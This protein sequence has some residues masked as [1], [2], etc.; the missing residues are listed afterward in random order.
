MSHWLTDRYLQTIASLRSANLWNLDVGLL[1]LPYLQHCMPPPHLS[2]IRKSMSDLISMGIDT[3]WFPIKEMRR[4]RTKIPVIECHEKSELEGT[5]Y[6]IHYGIH[7]INSQITWPDDVKRRTV[8]QFIEFVFWNTG[9]A[10]YITS[11][12]YYQSVYSLRDVYIHNTAEKYQ[13]D[14]SGQHRKGIE[15]KIILF[16][17]IKSESRWIG[18]H[19]RDERLKSSDDPFWSNPPE[20]PFKFTLNTLQ[21]SLSSTSLP[22]I[23]PPMESGNTGELMV[24]LPSEHDH[25][26]PKLLAKW[27]RQNV[28]SEADP[29]ALSLGIVL[30][31]WE[32]L[33]AKSR[34]K[35]FLISA[36][37]FTTG[38][39]KQ[40]WSTL[41]TDASTLK[42]GGLVA[43]EN[44]AFLV[45]K[46]Q[47]VATD[48]TGVSE[49]KAAISHCIQLSIPSCWHQYIST[50]EATA[51][52]GI[53]EESS[54]RGFSRKHGGV[55]PTIN[56]MARS[57]HAMLRRECLG[58]L[59]SHTLSGNIPIELQNRSAYQAVSNQKINDGFQAVIKTLVQKTMLYSNEYP[60]VSQAIYQLQSA[61]FH[62]S[63][64]HLIG[65]QL[66]AMQDSMVFTAP[67]LAANHSHMPLTCIV[68]DLNLLE[69]YY[70]WMQQFASADRAVG[71]L[72]ETTY[73]GSVRWHRDKDS[74][75]YE[76][77]K[78]QLPPERLL[79]QFVEVQ[80]A[81]KHLKRVMATYGK[82]IE[83]PIYDH[84]AMQFKV[85]A[86]NS[87]KASPLESK[88]AE[89]KAK[90]LWGYKP[91][92]ERSNAHRHW[93]ATKLT[94]Q[95]GESY[96]DLL[97]GHH[98]DGLDQLAPESSAS[99]ITLEVL[100]SASDNSLD[101]LGF[102]VLRSPWP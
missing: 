31:Y 88:T 44:G 90:T 45:Y 10:D 4:I 91:P 47:N 92:H 96:A 6:P 98:I 78:I 8:I 43:S 22:T 69:F 79:Q 46:I 82:D 101:H 86:Q 76:E 75:E 32:F 41:S 84:R 38:I 12:G 57:G 20:I 25:L 89:Q 73:I 11:T 40:R 93:A 24:V 13:L 94:E 5:E 34:F 102:K 61:W 55:K 49:N 42:Q 64:D 30:K 37:A 3:D 85:A 16:N 18:S 100:R 77:S 53:G 81:R 67:K 70:F 15:K 80:K 35:Q 21:G 28:R 48:F 51:T 83:L 50:A 71:E 54:L 66:S 33:L 74:L 97:L 63:S 27:S 95:Y 87:V 59:R 14:V 65:S 19:V 29:G 26:I 1:L 68:D 23:N 39:N 58:E 52:S 60:L 56:R 72:T 62:P 99:M 36:L 2:S 17:E 7:R 9:P